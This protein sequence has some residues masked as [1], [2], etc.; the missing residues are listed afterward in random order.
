MLRVIL[1]LISD[2][3]APVKAH[4]AIA[5]QTR[6]DDCMSAVRKDTGEHPYAGNWITCRCQSYLSFTT[7]MVC[8]YTDYRF[9]ATVEGLVPVASSL[10]TSKRPNVRSTDK[11]FEPNTYTPRK[12]R[13]NIVTLIVSCAN[14]NLH[15]FMSYEC[16]ML[17]RFKSLYLAVGESPHD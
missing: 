4:R 1:R 5:I 2:L 13:G 7:T 10:T 6:L 14:K 15:I 16:P 9:R 17:Q 3:P 12:R 11:P 8:R